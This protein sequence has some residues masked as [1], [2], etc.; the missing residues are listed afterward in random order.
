MAE[1]KSITFII[2]RYSK[3]NNFL[4]KTILLYYFIIVSNPDLQNIS[5]LHWSAVALSGIALIGLFVMKG[6]KFSTYNLWLTSFIIISFTSS[7]WALNFKLSLGMTLSLLMKSMPLMTVY[8][9]VNT[10]KDFYDIL[11][12]QTISSFITSIYIL[13]IMDWSMLGKARIGEGSVGELWNANYIGLLLAMS[14]FGVFVLLKTRSVKVMKLPYI[15]LFV[16]F[17]LIS[18]FTGS[19]KAVLAIVF[20]CCFFILLTSKKSKISNGLIAIVISIVIFSAVMNI[21]ILYNILGSR[22]EM[23]FDQF[24]SSSKVDGSTYSRMNMINYG[25]KWFSKRPVLGHGID[26]YQELYLNEFSKSMYSHNNYIELLVGTGILGTIIYYAGYAY[27]LLRTFGKNYPLVAFGTVVIS[28]ICIIEFGLVSYFSFYIQILICL[29]FSS[30]KLLHRKGII[31]NYH[32]IALE[33][34]F[35]K[36]VLREISN[37]I[38]VL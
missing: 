16:I 10:E 5:V 37:N 27:I 24:G 28:V 32:K 21:P 17:I 33:S 9:L 34:I 13:C 35:R 2:K 18:L 31:I 7:L 20:S 38:K 4:T 22:I 8:A 36:K 30:I 12:I 11:K 6:A 29:S 25:I 26:N 15:M 19:R 1:L 23:L 14:A 3:D